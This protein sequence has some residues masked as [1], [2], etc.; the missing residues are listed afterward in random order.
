MCHVQ[1]V[2]NLSRFFFVVEL[3]LA[4][5]FAYDTI[6]DLIPIHQKSRVRHAR[7]DVRHKFDNADWGGTDC[8]PQI[9]HCLVLEYISCEHPSDFKQP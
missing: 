4:I 3:L 8:V 7:Y 1:E 6:V 9:C 2:G 5:V